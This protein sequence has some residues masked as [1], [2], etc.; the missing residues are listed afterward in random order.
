MQNNVLL[1]DTQLDELAKFRKTT[2]LKM[3]AAC[4]ELTQTLNKSKEDELNNLKTK[5]GTN[6]LRKMSM[7][8]VMLKKKLSEV[9][10]AH[11]QTLEDIKQEFKSVKTL[12]E[13]LL[14][15]SQLR[16]NKMDESF[17]TD[18]Q[19]A[20]LASEEIRKHALAE[21][22]SDDGQ[23]SNTDMKI[24]DRELVEM[25]AERQQAFNEAVSRVAAEKDKT[26]EELR[27][28]VAEL[29]EQQS[30]NQGRQLVR[31]PVVSLKNVLL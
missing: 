26:I 9:K 17:I 18:K 29:S 7:L 1:Q 20:S 14:E 15:S 30:R 19:S 24:L 31:N 6:H 22:M 10:E 5:L 27:K 3:D 13:Q 21:K 12:H 11:D 28:K 4:E 2:E 23:M 25:V 16:M 8:S